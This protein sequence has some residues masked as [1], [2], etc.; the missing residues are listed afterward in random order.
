MTR[1]LAV[2]AVVTSLAL[3]TAWTSLWVRTCTVSDTIRF[4]SPAGMSVGYTCRGGIAVLTQ[5]FVTPPEW[6]WDHAD[7]GSPA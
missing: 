5:P 4:S 3:V 6:E 7:F 2:L 1:S